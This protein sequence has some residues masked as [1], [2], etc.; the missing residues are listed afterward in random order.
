[1]NR[2]ANLP[3]SENDKLIEEFR[4]KVF[5]FKPSKSKKPKMLDIVDIQKKAK[6]LEEMDNNEDVVLEGSFHTTRRAER[7]HTS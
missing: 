4:L 3:K 2:P 1:M 5:T 6:L 7:H